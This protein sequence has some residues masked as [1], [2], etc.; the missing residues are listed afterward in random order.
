MPL[1]KIV[2][3]VNYTKINVNKFKH[4]KQTRSDATRFKVVPRALNTA[5]SKN[6]GENTVAYPGHETLSWEYKN[7]TQ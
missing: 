1:L 5:L 2:N 7:Q 6:P 3:L 4:E